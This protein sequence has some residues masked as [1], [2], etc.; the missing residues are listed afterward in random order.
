MLIFH[1]TL[2]FFP[3]FSSFFLFWLWSEL[4]VL[5]LSHPGECSHVLHELAQC[6]DSFLGAKDVW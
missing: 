2:F 3:P 6:C 4:L 1:V 5:W